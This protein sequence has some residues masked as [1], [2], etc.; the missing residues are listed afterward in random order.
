MTS[1]RKTAR[2]WWIL[3]LLGATGCG[4]CG[5]CGCTGRDHLVFTAAV[6]GDAETVREALDQDPTLLT[7][8]YRSPRGGRHLFSHDTGRQLVHIA[9]AEG[10][11]EILQLLKERGADLNVEANDGMRHHQPVH[12]AAQKYQ[13]KA[14]AWL[15]DNGVSIEAKTKTN[16]E[17][18]LY[19]AAESA[20]VETVELLLERGAAVDARFRSDST[21]WTALITVSQNSSDKSL[22]VAKRLL[23]K[24]ADVNAQDSQS[25]L[26]PLH[27]AARRG[28]APLVELLLTNRADVRAKDFYGQTPIEA[29]PLDR[30]DVAE[31]LITTG[32]PRALWEKRIRDADMPLAPLPPKDK[33]G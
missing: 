26:T 14:I 5:G 6:K 7:E 21:T 4:G 17:T 20:S 1:H 15:L 25:Q 31:L 24:G 10:R 19:T 9:A 29:V 8:T 30:A 27:N 32:A 28:H 16:D 18:P 22:V 11:I 12:H 2:P 33:P 13:V 3:V 23:E